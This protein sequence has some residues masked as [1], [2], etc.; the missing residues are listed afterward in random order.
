MKTPISHIVKKYLDISG[1]RFNMD[2]L[3]LQLL[4]HPDFPNLIAVIDL[5]N[6]LGIGHY[7]LELEKELS[8]LSELPEHFL[9]HIVDKKGPQLAIIT[10]KGNQL[11]LETDKK[12]KRNISK[13]D[14][15]K[16]WSGITICIHLE[17]KNIAE[18][19]A[20][21]ITSFNSITQI[22]TSIII[23]SV[24]LMSG[25]SIFQLLSFSF[26]VIGIAISVLIIQQEIG[27][28]STVLAKF[29][30]TSE[31][32]SCEATIN[33]K[34]ASLFGVLKLSDMG[35]I[36]FSSQILLWI[37]NSMNTVSFDTLIVFTSYLSLPVVLYS[38]LYQWIV[39]K[40]WCPLCLGVVGVLL[41]QFFSTFL[42]SS[43][44]LTELLSTSLKEVLM[45]LMSMSFAIVGWLFVKPLLKK[46]KEL[47]ILKVQNLKFKRNFSFF[48]AS[49]FKEDP[50]PNIN[51]HNEIILGN[52]NAPIELTLIT[53]PLCSYCKSAHEGVEKILDVYSESVKVRIRFSVDFSDTE[54]KA[55]LISHHLLHLYQREGENRCRIALNEVYALDNSDKEKWSDKQLINIDQKIIEI[56]EQQKTWGIN[57]KVYLTPTLLINNY[58]F[59]REEYSIEDLIYFI[60]DLQEE[61]H[62]HYELV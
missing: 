13:E 22:I 23:T 46:G 48:K 34:G 60:E 16:I 7:A 35:I 49:L 56:L 25:V 32:T 30:N 42:Y 54:D 40:K 10:K 17:E 57:E 20:G 41:V 12:E 31:K 9:A 59:N 37:F 29:C 38:I 14:F 15:I 8:I 1:Y 55:T 3:N 44:F 33:S 11:I 19:G 2:E 5:F 43:S 62:L 21:K 27:Y 47:S 58:V 26:S 6:H 4:S 45:F 28:N 39:I 52:P 24:F 18:K 61:N 51:I 53:N 50:I 36:Y